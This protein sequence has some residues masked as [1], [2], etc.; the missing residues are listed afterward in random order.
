MRWLVKNYAMQNWLLRKSKGSGATE[1]IM[2]DSCLE[3]KFADRKIF[4][5]TN[6]NIE[7]VDLI[8][9][10]Q[11]SNVKHPPRAPVWKVTWSPAVSTV[12]EAVEPLGDK[13]WLV[14]VD[15]RGQPLEVRMQ[16]SFWPYSWLPGCHNVACH[17]AL[18]LTKTELAMPLPLLRR[19]GPECPLNHDPEQT[20]VPLT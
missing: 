8:H 18:L 14:E 19:N 11:A 15:H 3:V 6:Y 4:F 10:C 5:K 20:S 7:D 1:I 12:C 17:F 2:G 9:I 16:P 13:A